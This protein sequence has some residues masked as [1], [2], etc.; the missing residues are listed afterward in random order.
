MSCEDPGDSVPTVAMI[1]G[2][3][4]H[5]DQSRSFEGLF[6]SVVLRVAFL[7]SMVDAVGLDDESSELVDEVGDPQEVTVK[8]EDRDIHAKVG[9]VCIQLREQSRP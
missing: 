5:D 4:P 6:P 8:I 1:E 7:F 3:H 9:E 2:R